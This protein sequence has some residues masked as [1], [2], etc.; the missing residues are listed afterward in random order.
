[1][2]QK[3]KCSILKNANTY[4]H[5]IAI[6]SLCI[7][8][9]CGFE[10]S[11][12][13]INK[14]ISHILQNIAYGYI[15]GYIIYLITMLLKNKIDRERYTWLIYDCVIKLY[16]DISDYVD[17][18]CDFLEENQ[19]CSCD[20]ISAEQQ[21]QLEVFIQNVISDVNAFDKYIHTLK[22]SDA[23]CLINIKNN[24]YAIESIVK[25]NACGWC[26]IVGQELLCVKNELR[27]LKRNSEL[28]NNR[29]CDV[30]KK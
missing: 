10:S 18:K 8:L 27:H 14:G 11:N 29:W 3:A 13:E 25:S 24:I 15:G 6:V 20:T 2:K 28:L 5:I 9:V 22:N 30:V 4:L 23:V 12:S 7:I 19:D 1:M 26:H 21:N 17:N 16:S